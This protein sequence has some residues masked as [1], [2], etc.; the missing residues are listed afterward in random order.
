MR[1]KAC[2]GVLRMDVVALDPRVEVELVY[3]GLAGLTSR[4]I[5]RDILNEVEMKGPK[6]YDEF[7]GALR[8][9]GGT[10]HLAYADYVSYGIGGGDAVAEFHFPRTMYLLHEPARPASGREPRVPEHLA[11]DRSPSV[12]PAGGVGAPPSPE[13]R[14]ELVALEA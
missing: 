2:D 14:F 12:L 11:L 5:L 8:R 7:I 4:S 3:D 6:A 13:G 9:H 1:T 10:V